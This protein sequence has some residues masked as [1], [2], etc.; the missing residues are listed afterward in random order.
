MEAISLTDFYEFVSKLTD[1]EKRVV[2]QTILAKVSF[3]SGNRKSVLCE[4]RSGSSP[5]CPHCGSA[6]IQRRGCRGGVGHYWCVDCKKYFSDTTHTTIAYLKKPDLFE[7]YIACLLE[8]K[9]LRL[10]E[11][12]LGI[13][14]QTSFDWRHK[15]LSAFSS[16]EPEKIGGIV[17][18]DEMELPISQKGLKCTSRK[19]RKRGSDFR[20]NTGRYEANTVQVVAAVSRGGSGI[21]QPVN[22]KKITSGLLEKSIGGRIE[23]GSILMTDKNR[24][25]L[26]FA[27]LQD[28]ITHKTVLSHEHVNPKD[29]NVHVQTVNAKHN[30]LREF[31][32]PFHGVSSKYLKNYTNW[33]EY[34][35]KVREKSDV[36]R[37][38]LTIII[39]QTPVFEFYKKIVAD[40]ILIRP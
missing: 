34:M 5:V 36:V 30:M 8:R 12:E 13:S 7:K 17:E 9:S 32:K 39:T 22:V 27:A 37:A 19:P 16:L 40:M 28:T 14:H 15:I 26:R 23:R 1:D 11:K 31:L 35:K 3:G 2:A 18:C 6:H 21:L 4:K 29:K 33:F 20:R 25:F 38:I 10:C 24:A